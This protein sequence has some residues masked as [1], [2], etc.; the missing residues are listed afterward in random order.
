MEFEFK[1]ELGVKHELKPELE[2]ELKY[3]KMKSELSEEKMRTQAKLSQAREAQ[4]A[5]QPA[6]DKSD[7]FYH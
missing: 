5:P 4:P 3:E 2:L 6:Q 1:S 7:A